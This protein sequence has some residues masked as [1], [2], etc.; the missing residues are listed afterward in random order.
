VVVLAESNEIRGPCAHYHEWSEPEERAWRVVHNIKKGNWKYI[1]Y[2]QETFPSFCTDVEV[3][4]IMDGGMA[5]F[6][7][8]TSTKAH[9]DVRVHGKN[10]GIYLRRTC[11]RQL[12]DGVA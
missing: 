10:Y 8:K 7:K 11:E 1:Y 5:C 6:L 12:P 2:V 4:W 3:Q 9:M